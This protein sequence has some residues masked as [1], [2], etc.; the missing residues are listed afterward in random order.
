MTESHQLE[1]LESVRGNI[2]IPVS[3][4]GTLEKEMSNFEENNINLSEQVENYE[5]CSKEIIEDESAEEK[6]ENSTNKTQIKPEKEDLYEESFTQ[7]SQLRQ[8]LENEDGMIGNCRKLEIST[9]IRAGS[10]TSILENPILQF[11]LFIG[12]KIK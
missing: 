10:K 11:S 2:E 5:T 9:E 3:Q 8:I 1:I 4:S 7:T 6:D 12:K